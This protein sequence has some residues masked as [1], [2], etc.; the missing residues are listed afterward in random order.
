MN[1]K[2]RLELIESAHDIGIT[3]FDHADIYEIPPKKT[4]VLHFHNP[5]CHVPIV[6]SY[7]NVELQRCVEHNL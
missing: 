3:T 6:N 7:L 1:T 4:L 5:L 2:K